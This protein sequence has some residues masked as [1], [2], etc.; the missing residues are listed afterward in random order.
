MVRY[1]G[2]IV[3]KNLKEQLLV[4]RGGGFMTTA[5]DVQVD[6]NEDAMHGFDDV[7]VGNRI[8]VVGTLDRL[9]PPAF[10][11]GSNSIRINDARIYKI[12]R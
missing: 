4:F 2:T 6:L 1:T 3:R 7:K 11:F 12:A 10:G 8:T 9:V 5:Y